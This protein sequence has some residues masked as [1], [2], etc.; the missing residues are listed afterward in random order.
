MAAQGERSFWLSALPTAMLGVFSNHGLLEPKELYKS[1][2]LFSQLTDVENETRIAK[3]KTF[4]L[5]FSLSLFKP[6]SDGFKKP[7]SGVEE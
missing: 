1:P 5:S 3:K 2:C 4:S 7:L 6:L